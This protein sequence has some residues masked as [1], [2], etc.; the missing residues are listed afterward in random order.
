MWAQKPSNDPICT[1]NDQS[2]IFCEFPTQTYI[3]KGC[4][5]PNA[6]TKSDQNTINKHYAGPPQTKEGFDMWY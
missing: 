1:K 2:E 5:V 4:P 3:P 6:Y